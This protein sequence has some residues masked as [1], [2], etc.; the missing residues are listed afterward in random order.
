MQKKEAYPNSLYVLD[1]FDNQTNIS[2]KVSRSSFE[3]F[4]K[5]CRKSAELMKTDF[6]SNQWID[7]NGDGASVQSSDKKGS[8]LTS[9]DGN[10]NDAGMEATVMKSN[11]QTTCAGQDL[12]AGKS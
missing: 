4:Q 10:D 3:A 6:L 11:L 9:I 5:Y 8:S 12:E 2:T 7:I 1:Y